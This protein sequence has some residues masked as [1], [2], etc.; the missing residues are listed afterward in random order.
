M[1][2]QFLTNDR[3]ALAFN[4]VMTRPNLA[5]AGMKHVTSASLDRLQLQRLVQGG[6]AVAKM[7]ILGVVVV[8]PASRR[9][10]DEMMQSWLASLGV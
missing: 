7:T 4:L 1:H 10:D 6:G 5:I 3:A 2:L 8:D 9:K